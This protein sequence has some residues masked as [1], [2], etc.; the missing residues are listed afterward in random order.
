MSARTGPS[1]LH[2][3]IAEAANPPPPV[4]AGPP[5]VPAGPPVASIPAG[6]P[7][8]PIPAG[9]PPL[10]EDADAQQCRL[11]AADIPAV[12][13][14][15]LDLGARELRCACQACAVLFDRATAGGRR[16]RLIPDRRWQLPGFDLDDAAWAALS[17]P[18]EMAFFFHDTRAGRAV[19][20]YP[21]P[22]GAVESLLD[23][24]D[25]RRIVLANP[26]LEGLQPDTEALLVNRA[27]GAGDHWLVP[28]DDC[29]ALV[30]LIRTHW[31]GLS[32]GTVV[33]T[34]LAA[35]FDALRERARTVTGRPAGVG[36][37][38]GVLG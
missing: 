8:V 2:R 6:P 31:T 29:Y 33:W 7:A 23:L 32:G 10:P 15:L 28:I 38:K 11:C 1:R 3:L 24:S 27:R 37:A 5:A 26:V 13:R 22:A 25:W 19:C 17:I 16:Y 21:S 9:A 34:R 14:H 30:G 35:Y 4:S 18:V 12:H 36:T 20:F